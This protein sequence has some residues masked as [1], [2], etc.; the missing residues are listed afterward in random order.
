MKRQQG[1]RAVN[2]SGVNGVQGETPEGSRGLGT[3][4]AEC[5]KFGLCWVLPRSLQAWTVI[6]K[7]TA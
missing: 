1:V 5:L 3:T 6:V 2:G 4:F 7:V